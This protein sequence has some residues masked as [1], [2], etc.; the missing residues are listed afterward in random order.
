MRDTLA[1]QH[2]ALTQARYQMTS[3]ELNLLACL[4][5]VTDLQTEGRLK[6]LIR[7]SDLEELSGKRYK[8]KDYDHACAL[9]HERT[10]LIDD[11]G[12][13]RRYS[14]V[15]TSEL[16]EERRQLLLEM[17]PDLKPWFIDLD[18]HFTLYQLSMTLRLASK[19]SKRIY[20]M[21]CQFRSTGMMRVGL[22]ELKER[23]GVRWQDVK[24]GDWT[25]HYPVTGKFQ[26]RVLDKACEDINTNT[27]MQISY[28]ALKS[29]KKTTAYEF[30]IRHAPTQQ[31]IPFEEVKA[32]VAIPTGSKKLPYPPGA[33]PEI[34]LPA[35]RLA[36]WQVTRILDQFDTDAIHKILYQV[37][38]ALSEGKIF[39]LGA[40][41]ASQFEKQKPIG[42]FKQSEAVA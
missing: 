40:Y 37:D 7:I 13:R 1:K 4:I 21:V 35:Y 30:C 42:I 32:P 5:A 15:I 2:N 3:L 22:N 29:G 36:Q 8:L 17:H 18:K 33:P 24:S 12:K 10:A 20:Q 19:Y 6:V 25:D 41:T 9:L 31:T 27:D 34:R 26:Q 23:L 39:N 16:D 28:R 14:L 38:L 11:N